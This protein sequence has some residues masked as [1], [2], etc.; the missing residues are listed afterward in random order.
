MIAAG[1]IRLLS[2]TRERL[3]ASRGIT[4][5]C[6]AIWRILIFLGTF[7][8]IAYCKGIA[9]VGLFDKSIFT[10]KHNVLLVDS[11]DL[12]YTSVEITQRF[13]NDTLGDARAGFITVHSFQLPLIVLLIQAASALIAYTAGNKQI[14]IP[15]ESSTRYIMRF[16][17]LFFFQVNL[18]VGR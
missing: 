11:I 4:Q 18:P 10:G 16:E 12:S 9:I 6:F 15:F 17:E 2:R 1:L 7:I 8:F 14:K 3:Q 5:G 13:E